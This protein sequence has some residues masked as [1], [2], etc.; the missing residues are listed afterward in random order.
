MMSNP[1]NFSD[2]LQFLSQFHLIGQ[3]R[4]KRLNDWLITPKMNEKSSTGYVG[5]KNL[6]C[7]CYMNGFLQQIFMI[8]SFREAVFAVDDPQ[9]TKV[10]QE[11]NLLYQLKT[12]FIALEK[13]EQ[14]YYTPK[15]FCHSF[16]GVMFDRL[17]N[18]IKGV[19]RENFIKEH[20]GGVISN[21]ILSKGCQHYSER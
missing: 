15:G 14:Q 3:W 4:T 13:S 16:S 11:D 7:I 1:K 19:A 2:A 5:I 9:F 12:L 20:F 8:P 21:E 6:G 10:K 18:Q 17:E